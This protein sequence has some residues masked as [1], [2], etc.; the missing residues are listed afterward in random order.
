M[1]ELDF[2][3]AEDLIEEIR[4]T[5][6]YGR[7][8]W[9]AAID[10]AS[11]NLIA[12]VRQI[13]IAVAYF[14]G[15]WLE[16]ELSEAELW[17]FLRSN[18]HQRAKIFATLAAAQQ[19][20]AGDELIACVTGFVR[21]ISELDGTSGWK[22]GDACVSA[23]LAAM[24]LRQQLESMARGGPETPRLVMSSNNVAESVLQACLVK[25]GRIPFG[26]APDSEL[27]L[28]AK[29]TMEGLHEFKTSVAPAANE[30]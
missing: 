6:N 5:G 8:P 27:A 4:S 16:S 18:L 11:G 12:A 7:D 25:L 30:R 20:A 2:I 10:D 3:S 19:A 26:I 17:D 9:I 29:K 1:A 15:P 28:A 22:Y 23:L 14:I 13:E 21:S 24:V